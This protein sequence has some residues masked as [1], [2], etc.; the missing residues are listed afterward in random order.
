MPYATLSPA[1]PTPAPGGKMALRDVASSRQH[2]PCP[3][4]SSRQAFLRRSFRM[5]GSLFRHYAPRAHVPGSRVL[6]W[7]RGGIPA[8]WRATRS[9]RT[10]SLCRYVQPCPRTAV[11]KSLTIAA[12]AVAQRSDSA[13][14]EPYFGPDRRDVLAGRVGTALGARGNKTGNNYDNH[15][16]KPPENGAG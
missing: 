3:V 8:P 14:V 5:H 2:S 10:G 13:G 11:A 15:R 16:K 7:H 12:A 9:L 4:S 1:S 6:S